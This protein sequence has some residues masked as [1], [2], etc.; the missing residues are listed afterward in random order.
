[1]ISTDWSMFKKEQELG[2]GAFG[3]VYKVKCLKTSIV[4]GDS[5]QRV[6]MSATANKIGLLRRKLNVR[7]EGVNMATSQD[8]NVRTLLADQCYVIKVID[9]SKLSKQNAIEALMEIDL[10]QRLDSHFIVGY[11]DSFIVEN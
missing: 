6:E 2:E 9:T 5:G 11:F 4:Q 3:T 1:M 7:V 8:K 10:L